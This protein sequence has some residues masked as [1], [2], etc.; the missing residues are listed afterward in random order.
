MAGAFQRAWPFPVVQAPLRHLRAEGADFLAASYADVLAARGFAAADDLWP[1]VRA[2]Q[3]LFDLVRPALVVCDSG[4]ALCLA[5]YG[6]LPVVHVG[7]AFGL[8]PAG[9]AAF[10]RLIPGR[11]LL[12][13]EEQLL[14][15]VR[16]VQRRRGLPAPDTLPGLFAGGPRFLTFLPQL[17]PYRALRAEP[18]V[19]PLG[20]ALG[21]PLQLPGR[22]AYFAYLNADA[23]GTIP[24]LT[25]LA[26]AG[27]PGTAYLRGAAP[28]ARE[29]LRRLGVEVL[30]APA[31]AEDVLPRAAAVVHHGGAGLAEQALAAGRPQLLLPEHLEQI[32]NAQLLDGLGA[33]RYLVGRFPPEAAAEEL[34]RLLGESRFADQARAAAEAVRAAGPWAPLGRVVDCC[35]ALAGQG[36]VPFTV[37]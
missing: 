9:A 26:R 19:G 35:L 18:H 12:V 5:A 17:D 25:A 11:K 21:P 7:H 8:P 34:G 28:A 30:E 3:G 24:L 37:S 2:W 16:E 14:A 4:P 32:L 10:P 29:G 13:P 36:A 31:P 23:P 20:Y 1:L 33:G 15:A 6:V 27:W 22:L